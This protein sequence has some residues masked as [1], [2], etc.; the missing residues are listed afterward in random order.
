MEE[1]PASFALETHTHLASVTCRF[2]SSGLT[3]R[4]SVDPRSDPEN[5]VGQTRPEPSRD[6]GLILVN[7]SSP[8]VAGILA[9]HTK[10]VGWLPARSNDD[11][12]P[13]HRPTNAAHA[14]QDLTAA[15]SQRGKRRSQNARKRFPDRRG[16][17]P[18]G[19]VHRPGRPPGSSTRQTTGRG[20][21]AQRIHERARS[22]ATG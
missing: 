10:R 18:P 20:S 2:R 9:N 1:E 21:P 7:R 8:R 14:H 12:L 16:R 4:E 15:M 5:A 6:A 11:R 3:H 22:F 13:L 19:G 17:L